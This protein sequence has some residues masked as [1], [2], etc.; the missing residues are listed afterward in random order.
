[1]QR[2]DRA[3]SSQLLALTGAAL[4]LLGGSATPVAEDSSPPPQI[5]GHTEILFSQSIIER[6]GIEIVGAA[7]TA[8]ADREGAMGFA[9]PAPAQLLYSG[10]RVNTEG[11][12]D[13]ALGH[14]G[15]F[16]LA[17]DGI[18][19]NLQGFEL[20][21]GGQPYAFD[22][23][24]ANG[25]R[26]F[27][28]GSLQYTPARD[29]VLRMLNADLLLSPEFAKLLGRSDLEMTYV[30]IVDIIVPA[31]L[32]QHVA[33]QGGLALQGGAGS[34]PP[35]D[36]MS[37]IDVK[38]T[39]IGRLAQIGPREVGGRVAMAAAARLENVGE[40]TVEWFASIAPDSD[41]PAEIGPHPFLSLHFYRLERV[42]AGN[43]TLLDARLRQLGQ[44]DTKHAFFSVNSDCPCEG[45][46]LLYPTCGDVYGANTNANHKYLGPREEIQA[47]SGA[48]ER[49]G[50]HF[51]AFDFMTGMLDLP[52]DDFRS[53]DGFAD[54]PD[55]FE[56]RLVV[57][58]PD[59]PGAPASLPETIGAQYFMESWYVVARDID[60]MNSMGHNQVLPSLSGDTW[61]F[62]ATNNELINGS[63]LDEF[64]N[65]A[66]PGAGAANQ[67]IDTGAGRLQLAV[68][69]SALNNGSFHYEYALMNFDFDQEISSFRVPL[70][71]GVTAS[72]AAFFDLDDDAG[73]N[74]PAVVTQGSAIVFTAPG[75]NTN[76]LGW[77]TLFNFSFDASAPGS[78][79]SVTLGAAPA[80]APLPAVASIVP[81][82]N[83]VPPP[84][85][86]NDACADRIAIGTGTTFGTLLTATLDGASSEDTASSLRDVWYEFTP[87][88]TGEVRI[89]TCGTNDIPDVDQGVNTIVSIHTACPGGPGNELPANGANNR[90]FDS[91]PS[92]LATDPEA[93]L[94]IDSSGEQLDS[95]FQSD[96]AISATLEQGTPYIIRV[97]EADAF[98]AD[99]FLLTVLEPPVNDDVSNPEPIGPG[100][101]TISGTLDQADADF[102]DDP[103]T[104]PDPQPSQPDVW[105]QFDP[106]QTG[107]IRINTCGTFEATGLDTVISVYDL[108]NGLLAANDD[109]Q[110]EPVDGQGL[111]IEFGNDPTVCD[112]ASG[113]FLDSGVALDITTLDSLF[114]QVT[115][116]AQ[117]SSNDFSLT[118]DPN[119]P[120]QVTLA[121]SRDTVGVGGT[122]TLSWYAFQ[123][124]TCTAENAW[125]GSRFIEGDE[126]V[127]PATTSTYRLTC[128]PLLPGPSAFAEVTVDV[129]SLANDP[130][131]TPIT[132]STSS[133]P[134]SQLVDATI[135]SAD[136]SDPSTDTC[137][138]PLADNDGATLW[139]RYTPKSS[140]RVA[141]STL[142]S[143][144]D[145]VLS[146][147]NDAPGCG[148]LDQNPPVACNDDAPGSTQ[149]QLEF[150][151]QLGSSYLVM[152]GNYDGGSGGRLRFDVPEPRAAL[153]GAAAL[154]TLAALLRRRSRR[155]R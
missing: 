85:G 44:S 91:T 18:V 143:D 111:P 86:S 98:P 148:S 109:Y 114:I 76:T 107:S 66:A 80:G 129:Q 55:S 1:M 53:H 133:L 71:V 138:N 136:P 29:G 99:D 142:G 49:V 110:R 123:S 10:A 65:P 2:R 118:V 87:S 72:N 39:N 93:C 139:Y 7:P 102:P 104:E 115:R 4:V 47:F 21:A 43:T 46:Q 36:P 155:A 28:L 113:S 37:E 9:I 150:D 97:T 58:E 92:N 95:G 15:G 144:Y 12:S 25:D 103:A 134:F 119:P 154:G 132:L 120:F 32:P 24:D 3:I 27:R 152:I 101:E 146:V 147:W 34:C 130:C 75:G 73:N 88:R 135:A 45:G 41:D 117:G 141:L 128:T 62:S 137:R 42:Q 90:F 105:Y 79:G 106:T 52:A 94:Q 145:T 22:L 59:L 51:D 56:H 83:A 61:S 30:A 64:V 60:I 126:V 116:F 8:D 35:P 153:L 33:A 26:W 121:A 13:G 50:S 84:P 23:V 96:S 81:D 20:R 77:G 89:H 19:L 68:K 57:P 31:D 149:S 151:A 131:A 11:F 70:P 74:W 122:S 124:A 100:S 108:A 16:S 54:H 17:F 63:I 38:L 127:T 125:L 78:A 5:V 48:W 14:V 69:T 140:G 112:G 6:L 67:M 82:P 40:G